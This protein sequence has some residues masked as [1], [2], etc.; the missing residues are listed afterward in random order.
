MRRDDWRRFYKLYRNYIDQASYPFDANL[1][2]PTAYSITEVQVAFLSD[3]IMEGGDFVEVLGKTPEGQASAKAVKEMLNYHFRYS[4]DIFPEIEKFI[5]QLLMYG[6]SVFKVGW[7]YR[8]EWKTRNIPEYDDT[9][10]LLSTRESL[11]A[12]EIANRPS[13]RTVDIAVFGVDPNASCVADA[14]YAFEEMWVDPMV[15]LEKQQLGFYKNVDKLMNDSSNSVNEGLMEREEDIGLT[16]FQN[17][18]YVERGKIHIVDYWGYLTKG[19]ENGKLKKRAKKQLFHVVAALSHSTTGGEGVPVI[20]LS[21]PSPYFHNRIPFIDTR[22]NACVGE[23][24]GVG[25]IEYCESLFCEQRDL[26]NIQLDNLSR[27]MNH[28]FIIRSGAQ[29]DENELVNRPSGI[30]HAE[31]PQGDIVPLRTEPFDPAVFKS[32]DDIRRDIEMTTGVNDF[33]TGQFN[34]A[35]G[36]ND[37]A[38]GISL[39][40][41]VAMKRMAHKG[42]MVQQAVRDIGQMVFNLVAQ[43]S[44]HGANVRILDRESATMYRFIDISPEALSREYDFHIINAAALGSRTARQTQLLQ[45]FQIM[46][47]VKQGDPSFNFDFNKFVLR[48]LDEMDIPNAQELLGNP[49]LMQ[50][51]PPSLGTPSSQMELYSPDEENRIMIETG[52][53]IAPKMEENHP[54]H[55]LVHQQAYDN[56]QDTTI[57]KIIAE[58]YNVHQNMSEQVKSLIAQQMSLD[59]QQ[60]SVAQQEQQLQMLSGGKG[61]TSPTGAGGQEAVIRNT[62]NQTAGNF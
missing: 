6:T 2:I 31:D 8:V 7:D 48:L 42:Q 21:Q 49:Q 41:N 30:I 19:W 35:T 25:D 57:K 13:G 22:I 33:V 36:F 37:T 26:R 29:I 1:A 47:Q 28:M 59:I 16:S 17:S 14:R 43:Y 58:H 44:P 5:R 50:G 34:S 55:M 40:Q 3:L 24:Y 52:Q 15:L 20:L 23:Y 54:H 4:I 9:G 27:S 11:Y 45:L 51:L 56:V 53:Y 61:A 60:N 39:I 46:G 18:P 32:Q 10:E 38:T 12:E 62:A